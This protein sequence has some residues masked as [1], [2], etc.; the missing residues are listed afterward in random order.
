M[1][2]NC[3]EQRVAEGLTSA[4]GTAVKN[5][6]RHGKLKFVSAQAMKRFR[7]LLSIDPIGLMSAEEQSYCSHRQR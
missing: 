5:S 7:S 2:V 1:S 4:V 6:W 3:H